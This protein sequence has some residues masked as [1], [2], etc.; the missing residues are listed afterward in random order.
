MGDCIVSGE[1]RGR[2]ELDRLRAERDGARAR[3]G[4]RQGPARKTGGGHWGIIDG[5]PASLAEGTSIKNGWTM[6]YADGA[7]HVNCL[8]IHPD[9]VLS[10]QMRLPNSKFKTW[11]KG[12]QY[13][14][15]LCKSVASQLVYPQPEPVEPVGAS[16]S[17][18]VTS[19]PQP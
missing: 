3:D 1:D 15:S 11:L 16:A 9:W 10:V 8:A 6:I 19:T 7:W 4:G 13:G 2:A 18:S 12:L 14:A 5:L 17:P